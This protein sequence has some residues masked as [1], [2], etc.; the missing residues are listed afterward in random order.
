MQSRAAELDDATSG[1]DGLD[2]PRVSN[3]SSVGTTEITNSDRAPLHPQLEVQIG[4][5][6]I[7]QDHITVVS[8]SYVQGA[9]EKREGKSKI[10]SFN[11][12]SHQPNK[13]CFV[14]LA[15]LGFNNRR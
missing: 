10:G 14:F 5:S 9:L 8:F 2:D 11:D 3:K 13:F 6:S 15:K 12:S 4:N 1:K 7:G